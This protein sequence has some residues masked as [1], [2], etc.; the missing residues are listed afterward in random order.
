MRATVKTSS[1]GNGIAARADRFPPPGIREDDRAELLQ[2]CYGPLGFG[3]KA[4]KDYRESGSPMGSGGSADSHTYIDLATMRIESQEFDRDNPLYHGIVNRAI[5]NILGD[6]FS[7]QGRTGNKTLN[8]ELEKLWREYGHA[9]E[10]RQMVSWW[11]LE[12]MALRAMMVEGDHGGIKTKTG[13]LQCIEAEQ[14]TGSRTTPNIVQGVEMTPLGQP[15]AYWVAPYGQRMG[16]SYLNASAAK[17][18][19]AEDFVHL[20]NPLRT[21]QTRGVPAM[22]SNFSMFHRISDVCDSEAIAWQIA[23]R[24]AMISNREELGA[25]DGTEGTDEDT[26]PG[27]GTGIS[28]RRQDMQQ[29]IFFNADPGETLQ[30]I[31]RK[32]PGQ[33]FPQSLTMFIRLLGLP[34]GLPLELILLDWSK[35]NYSSARAALEQAFRAF[36]CWQRVLKARWH[37]PIYTWQI[38]RWTQRGGPLA[39]WRGRDDLLK[40]EWIAPSFPW[41]D[42]LKE[43]QAWGER[44]D[45]GLTTYAEALKAAQNQDR[46]DVIDV[47]ANEVRDAIGIAKKL[48]AETGVEVPWQIFAG[49]SYSVNETPANAD[50]SQKPM[51]G[52]ADDNGND[53]SN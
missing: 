37:S 2:P 49:L 16:A 42:Q 52:S 9:P 30:P 14:I 21:S 35:T 12:R 32:I 39:R 3:Y 31:E 34:V 36:K 41:I 5:D 50:D 25:S 40:H 1:N 48:T 28:S 45:R 26:N 24:F 11:Q 20:I 33:S 7:L 53:Q 6:G 8:R 51:D 10:V 22:V 43:A 38:S 15:L 46:E 44:M 4:A 18:K 19:K 23:A 29:G 47:R 27:S 13:R 17:R